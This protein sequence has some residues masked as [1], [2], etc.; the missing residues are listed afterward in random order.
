VLK[1]IFI[2]VNLDPTSVDLPKN[3]ILLFLNQILRVN[4]STI[5][6]L[7][8]LFLISSLLGIGRLL[9]LVIR[10]V[11]PLIISIEKVDVIVI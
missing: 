3:H 10:F 2:S 6:K 5:F 9:S 11:R 1:V 4:V 8:I 7:I